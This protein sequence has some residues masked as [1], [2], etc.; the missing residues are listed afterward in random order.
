MSMIPTPHIEAKLDDIASV[1]LMP[2]D[3]LRAKY[4]AEHFLE[5]AVCVN[6]VRNMLAYTGEYKGKKIT[7]FGSGMGMPSIGIYS[8]ELFHFYNVDTIIRIGS[9]GALAQG[10]ELKDLV[11]GVGASTNSN[12]A[13]QFRL[14]GTIAP[15]ADFGLACKA[16]QIARDRGLRVK[17]GNILSSDIFYN[18]YQQAN[19]EW[20]RMGILAV[21]MEAA[22]LYLN[23]AAAHKK[24]VCLL[25]ISDKPFTGESLD[26]KER[27]TGFADMIYTALELAAGLED[28]EGQVCQ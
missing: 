13:S 8:Y 1:V 28:E 25:S 17:A 16:V 4:V 2:G 23:A 22:A 3:P 10:V 9:A 26:A 7:I 19:A 27:Q 12:Y 15:L 14:P 5:N 18:D 11:V 20:A 24:A 6:S 21:E